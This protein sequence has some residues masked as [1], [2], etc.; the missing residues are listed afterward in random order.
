MYDALFFDTLH[1]IT[2]KNNQIFEN[3]LQE[4]DMENSI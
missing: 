1:V 2:K 4:H 3:V